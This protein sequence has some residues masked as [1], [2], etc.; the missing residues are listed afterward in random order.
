VEQTKAEKKPS[1]RHTF[2]TIEVQRRNDQFFKE[3]FEKVHIRV[4]YST[5]VV[6]LSENS[7]V[8]SLTF[9][10]YNHSFNNNKRGHKKVIATRPQRNFDASCQ[11]FEV[12]LLRPITGRIEHRARDDSAT[13][14][15]RL[16]KD[17]VS[18]EWV[19]VTRQE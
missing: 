9:I 16:G 13:G 18:S 11:M 10:G 3:S 6:N 5:V 8:V 1:S 17:P 4:Q 14:Y 15:L 7:S 19:S 12:L 2:H